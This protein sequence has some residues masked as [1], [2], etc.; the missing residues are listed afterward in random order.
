MKKMK[1]KVVIP[2]YKSILKK[3]EEKSLDNTMKKLSRYPIVFL[4]N[5]QVEIAPYLVKYPQASVMTVSD[6][7]LGVRRGIQG[8]NEMMMSKDFYELFSDAEY[9]LICHLD[10]WIFRDEIEQWCD[11]GYDMVAAPWPTRPIYRYFPIKQ[12]VSIRNKIAKPEKTERARMRNHIGN[13]G[14]CLRRV[15]TFRD[16]CVRYADKI[17]EYIARGPQKMLCNEDVFWAFEPKDFKLPSVEE[18]FNF[19]YDCKPHI[20]YRLNHKKV[21][22]GCHGYAR[23][24]RAKFWSQFIPDIEIPNT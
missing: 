23:K 17:Q 14:L 3:N 20:C 19:S 16:A 10:A 6:D 7:W 2:I 9:I 15:Q 22:M 24:S 4:V 8:Y 13:G 1:V 12:Y 5:D 21:P 11:A 18:S